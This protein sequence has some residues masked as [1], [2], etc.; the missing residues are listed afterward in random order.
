M[1]FWYVV[2]SMVGVVLWWLFR[3][4]V[5]LVRQLFVVGVVVVVYCVGVCRVQIVL[6]SLRVW[7]WLCICSVL[8]R[9]YFRF[10]SCSLFL[11]CWNVIGVGVL[12]KCFCLLWLDELMCSVLL[13]LLVLNRLYCGVCVVVIG[14]VSSNVQVSQWWYGVSES[15]LIF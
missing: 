1:F 3:Q 4:V 5:V 10:I 15:M 13:F 2:V 12:L 7:L 11:I 8:G 6:F 14:V 9:L